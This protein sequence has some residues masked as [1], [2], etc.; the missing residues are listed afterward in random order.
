MSSR[1]KTALGEDADH[2][3]TNRTNSQGMKAKNMK[4]L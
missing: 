4:N 2:L 1:R 3:D